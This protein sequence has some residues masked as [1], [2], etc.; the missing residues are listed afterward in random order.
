MEE[1]RSVLESYHESIESNRYSFYLDEDIVEAKYYR[2]MIETMTICQSTD[3]V[4][5]YFNTDGGDFDGMVA[6]IHAI[7][8]CLCPVVGVLYGKA[9]SAGS[10][11]LLHCSDI[12][13]GDNASMMVHGM[14]YGYGGK[15]SDVKAYVDFSSKQNT[16]FLKT[17]YSEFLTES[18]MARVENGDD[19]FFD[20]DESKV[21]LELMM[22]N[23]LKAKEE[24]VH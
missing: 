21:K 7:K 13:V 2:N 12:Y 11:I 18:E 17:T 4:I 5:I 6:I 9:Y 20:A 16:R 22:E 10:A 19:I 15:A 23:R 24:I 14:S 8:S 3:E 1:I